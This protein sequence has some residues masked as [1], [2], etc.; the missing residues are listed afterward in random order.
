M[1]VLTRKSGQKILIGDNI[2]ITIIKTSGEQ[3]SVG[4][5]APRSLSIYREELIR[6]I[7]EENV[8]G[9]LNR[10]KVNVKSLAKKL[11]LKEKK[12]ETPPLA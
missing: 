6:E 9:V 3:V 8:G 2:E 5:E 10:K 7:K 4:V 11:K 12:E 1:L